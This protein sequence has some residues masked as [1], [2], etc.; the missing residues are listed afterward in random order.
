METYYSCVPNELH[1]VHIRF[2]TAATA[3]LLPSMFTCSFE[4]KPGW[5]GKIREERPE[6]FI[7]SGEIYLDLPWKS[8]DPMDGYMR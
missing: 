4:G 8:W 6:K 3:P 2:P 1:H 5:R 7:V